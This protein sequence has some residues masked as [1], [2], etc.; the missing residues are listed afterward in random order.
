MHV[1]IEFSETSSDDHLN[2]ANNLRDISLTVDEHEQ[3]ERNYKHF[4][5]NI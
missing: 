1:T 4:L 5:V 2:G 3:G